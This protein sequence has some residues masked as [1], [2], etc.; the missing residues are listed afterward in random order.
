MRQYMPYPSIEEMKRGLRRWQAKHPQRL[1][2]QSVG[3]TLA[4]RDVLLCKVTDASV[5]DVDK[6]VVLITTTH[7]GREYN[8]STSALHLVKW[9]IG[10]SPLARETRRRQ[11]VLVMPACAP[12]AYAE[13]RYPGVMPDD[14][15]TIKGEGNPC[16]SYWSWTG[17]MRPDIN[18][19][20]VAIAKVMDRY[21]P[22]VHADLHGFPEA[23]AFMPEST[24]ISWGSGL[25]RC[26]NPEVIQ[27]MNIA[28]DRQGFGLRVTDGEFSAGA[29]R[30]TAPINVPYRPDS[31]RKRDHQQLDKDIPG[32][33]FFMRPANI[34]SCTF[35]Y[36]RY[37]ALSFTMEIGYEQSA[38]ARLQGL[39]EIGNQV[40]YSEYFHGYPTNH[41]GN[42][43][44]VALAGWGATAAE[45]RRSRV[46]LWSK[47][48]QFCFGY[49]NPPQRGELIA[50]CATTP[51]GAKRFLNIRRKV[52]EEDRQAPAGYPGLLA[53]LLP[54]IKR[55][56]HFDY[57]SI[58][59]AF[60][61]SPVKKY[62]C[63][64]PSGTNDG[65]A[66]AVRNGLAIRMFIPD[67]NA[68]I[69]QV[70]L[71]GRPLAASATDGYLVWSGSG[72][73]VQV[74]IPPRAVRE[75]HVVT[76]RYAQSRIYPYGFSEGDWRL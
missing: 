59:S 32:H 76:C 36:H 26:H 43:L 19:E 21:M 7:G 42:G 20:A 12:D 23:D 48:G 3:K 15:T 56:R 74:N 25:S 72:K 54:R 10:N 16:L 62:I 63:F 71:D 51:Q 45:R 29:V 68:A 41:M 69:E 14:E 13:K 47:F 75:F 61:R 46:E 2:V 9:L 18:P 6:Q 49:A 44:L 27:R 37:H 66:G 39:L 1:K 30:V 28:A 38:L 11:I 35:S 70:M 53:D 8:S 57:A 65:D 34:S 17:V 40:W 22:D 31:L 55:D 5:D 50:M 24:G 64:S 73:T 4:G 67:I 58:E 60:N 33:H 52:T